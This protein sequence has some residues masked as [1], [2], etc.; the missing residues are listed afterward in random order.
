MERAGRV[1]GKLKLSGKPVAPEEMV[2]AAWPIAVGKRLASRTGRVSLYGTTMVVDVEDA[3]WQSQLTSLT[4]QILGKIESLLGSSAVLKLEFRIG[5]QRR[6]PQ[7]VEKPSP[8]FDE[9]DGIQDPVFRRIY[10]ASRR[11][12]S[13]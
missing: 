1:I 6:M 11:R 10:I 13:A 8:L 5:V 4:G 3:V 9:G 12:A 2:R 7:R